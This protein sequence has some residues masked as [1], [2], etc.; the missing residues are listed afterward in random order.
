MDSRIQPTTPTLGC[1]ETKKDLLFPSLQRSFVTG[2]D[3]R[4]LYIH[5]RYLDRCLCPRCESGSVSLCI[6]VG[7]Y[8]VRPPSDE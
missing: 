3:L 6:R 1:R 4:D 8:G 2:G 5:W 7:L